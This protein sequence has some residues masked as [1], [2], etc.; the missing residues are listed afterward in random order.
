[1]PVNWWATPESMLWIQTLRFPGELP[2]TKAISRPSGD[3]TG[4]GS[5]GKSPHFTPGGGGMTKLTLWFAEDVVTDEKRQ[6]AAAMTKMSA[7]DP[8]NQLESVTPARVGPCGAAE[9]GFWRS[10]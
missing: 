8:N 3:A 9:T 5:M 1:M 7:S 6:A 4:L 10:L 2:L